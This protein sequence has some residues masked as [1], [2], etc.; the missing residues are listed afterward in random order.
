M[1]NIS[2]RDQS[3]GYIPLR[4]IIRDNMTEEIKYIDENNIKEL[5]P[6]N[7]IEEIKDNPQKENN[8]ISLPTWNIEP[9]LEI[10]RNIE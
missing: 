3:K 1:K 9:P 10:Q 6:N 2:E 8:K 4:L 5:E 7:K